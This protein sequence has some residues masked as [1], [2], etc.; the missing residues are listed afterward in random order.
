MMKGKIYGE[1]VIEELINDSSGNGVVWR[2]SKESGLRGAIKILNDFDSSTKAEKRRKRFVSEIKKLQLIMELGISGVMPILDHN[3]D[4]IQPWFVMPVAS[5][6]EPAEDRFGWA[7]E[8]SITVAQCLAAL[9]KEGMV[10]RDIK[11]NN[12]L[13][14][15]G[16]VVLSDFGLA[17]IKDDDV[18]TK[19][20]EAVGSFGYTAPE[21]VSHSD[22]P[23]FKCDVYAL[24]KTSW[25]LFTGAKAPPTGDLGHSDDSLVVRGISASSSINLE[26]LDKLLIAST[27][28][29]LND[30][31][32]MQQFLDGL[33]DCCLSTVAN[34]QPSVSPILRAKALFRDPAANNRR[35]RES[36]ELFQILVSEINQLFFKVWEGVIE[37]LGW[38]RDKISGGVLGAHT[39][40]LNVED[41]E[42][43]R[44][45]YTGKIDSNTY[46]IAITFRRKHTRGEPRLVF[47]AVIAIQCNGDEHVLSS[48]EED[49][50]ISGPQTTQIRQRLIAF[51]ENPETQYRTLE[52]LKKLSDGRTID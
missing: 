44:C 18:L 5:A 43:Q 32:T 1:W 10:H 31:P 6:L 52:K 38:S 39:M 24:A 13:F 29:D 2:V 30:R 19:T 45:F 34:I 25:V 4:E 27:A 51:A 50:Y 14:L 35:D 20:G 7:L 16:K 21:C 33:Q 17:R 49:I 3:A 26:E 36:K 8:I 47:S 9:H 40:T 37:E 41:W 42:N 22:E 11:P 28:R 15:D 23:Q 12:I 46:D 48:I